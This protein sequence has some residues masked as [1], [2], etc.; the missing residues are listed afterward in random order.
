MRT[1]PDALATSRARVAEPKTSRRVDRLTEE[2]VR[3]SAVGYRE[4]LPGLSERIWK[5]TIN[6]ESKNCDLLI[7]KC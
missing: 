7:L 2:G 3:A 5:S 4:G 1:S 6:D